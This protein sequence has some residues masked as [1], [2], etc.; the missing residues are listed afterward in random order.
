MVGVRPIVRRLNNPDNRARHDVEEGVEEGNVPKRKGIM[1]LRKLF[2]VVLMC[3]P[4]L[5][6]AQDNGG[7]P[8]MRK[9]IVSK[10]QTREFTEQFLNVLVSARP[11]DAFTLMKNAAP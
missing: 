10:D 2:T 3:T 9:Q 11:F 6:L 7:A 5:V 4:A 8:G 1:S